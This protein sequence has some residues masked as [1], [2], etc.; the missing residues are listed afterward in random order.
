MS[1]FQAFLLQQIIRVCVTPQRAFAQPRFFPSPGNHCVNF[2]YVILLHLLLQLASLLR[3]PFHYFAFWKLYVNRTMQHVPFKFGILAWFIFSL[4][5]VCLSCFI[6]FNYENVFRCIISHF[7][8]PFS[9]W[10]WIYFMVNAFYAHL[11]RH[12][13]HKGVSG[14]YL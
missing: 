6:N 5:L 10:L 13:Q 12:I 9:L 1:S 2:I 11:W 7:I 4:L 8:S 3:K 14:R